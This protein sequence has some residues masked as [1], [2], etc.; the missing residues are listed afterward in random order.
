MFIGPLF[1][2]EALTA[3][4]RVQHFAV[5]V[6]AVAALLGLTLTAWQV[7]VGSGSLEG[8]GELSRFG[9]VA[10]RLV[11]PLALTVAVLFSALLSAAAVSQEKSRGTLILLLL[12]DLRNHELV[13]GRLLASLLSVL[14]AMIAVTPYYLMLT[15]FGGID[16]RQVLGAVAVTAAGSFAAGSLGSTLAL[17]REKTFQALALT[18]AVLFLWIAMGE[19]I[20][21]GVFGRELVGSSAAQVAA[22]VSP[23]QALQ[24]A[25]TPRFG[26][27]PPIAG[28]IATVT[29][30]WAAGAA[31]SVGLGLLLNV[32]AIALVRVWNPSREARPMGGPQTAT[33]STEAEAP[34]SPSADADAVVRRARGQSAEVHRVAG[35]RREVWDNP[36]LWREVRTWA[37]GKKVLAVKA[38][39]FVIFCLA[40]AAVARTADA[41]STLSAVEGVHPLTMAIAPV[42]VLSLVLVNAL[43]VTSLTGERDAKSLDLLLASELTAPELILGKLGGALWNTREMILLPLGLCGYL[44]YAG[45]TTGWE[46]L[47]LAIGFTVLTGFAGVLGLH[48]G[49]IY[50]SSRKAIAVSVGTLLFLFLGVSTCMRVMLAL[51]G[52][53][54]Y[55]LPPF[56]GAVFGGGVALYAALAWRN[57]STAMGIACLLAPLAT[58][59]AIVSFLDAKPSLAA[60]ATV[61]TFGFGTAAMLVPALSELDVASGSGSRDG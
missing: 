28:A 7:I 55:Q 30:D 35:Q 32:L 36:V 21:A 56:L 22:I 42:A 8:P 49:I 51:S 13:L 10:F 60:I 33:Q 31:F 39:Y 46:S 1:T 18:A 9:A 19:A 4:R 58:F 50:A 41:E 5:R 27:A 3:P 44:V 47:L 26:E 17:W 57:P 20:A 2:R 15:L 37:Y 25:L 29:P 48:C 24:A 43:A 23:W 6:L 45:A 40:A 54:E 59:Y 61:L 12:T 38:A 52:S 11:T 53:F 16:L 14:V 34:S